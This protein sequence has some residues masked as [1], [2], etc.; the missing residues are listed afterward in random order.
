MRRF[1]TGE[2]AEG[3]LARAHSSDYP[4][5]V[6][7]RLSGMGMLG[8]TMTEQDGGLGGTLM[9]AVITIQELAMVCPKSADVA[10]AGNF[11]LIRTFAEFARP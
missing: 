8:I 3:A 7:A 4:W 9:D 1:A 10:Q 5:D 2:L 6:A 11:G